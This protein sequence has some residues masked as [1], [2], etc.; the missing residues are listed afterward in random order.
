MQGTPNKAPDSVVVSN[1]PRGRCSQMHQACILSKADRVEREKTNKFLGAFRQDASSVKASRLRFSLGA[2]LRNST[3][4]TDPLI[5]HCL[6][7]ATRIAVHWGYFSKAVAPV[8]RITS[9]D[10]ATSKH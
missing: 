4:R 3:Y 2:V 9:G 8:A 7:T 6:I 1:C 10:F 5:N